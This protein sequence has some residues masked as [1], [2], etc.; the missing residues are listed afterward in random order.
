MADEI[1]LDDVTRIT[2]TPGP[3][4]LE[5]EVP[6]QN[7]S[8]EDVTGETRVFLCRCGQSSNKPFCDGTHNKVGFDGTE[9]ADHGPMADRRDAYEGDGITIYDDR[10]RC[11]HAGRCTGGLPAVWKMDEE[12]WI[13]A[14]GAPA[15][16]IAAT[17][18]SC[19]SGALTYALPGSAET[20]EEPMTHAVMAVPDGPYRVR[21]GVPVVSADGEPYELRARQTLCRC[22]QSKNKPFC[23]GSHW[24]A[25]F[26]DPA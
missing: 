5:G 26:K 15:A 22:G 14:L 25:G 8:G 2:V 17:V 21:G 19:P 6:I 24:Y 7:A 16:E 3:Y 9:V 12:P 4:M 10:S 1:E 13:D 18:A 20:V 23:D 11:A